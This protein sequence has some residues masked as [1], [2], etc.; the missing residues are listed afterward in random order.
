[1]AIATKFPIVIIDRCYDYVRSEVSKEG[2]LQITTG[3]VE[4]CSVYVLHC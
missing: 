3:T 1:M 4:N 2:I